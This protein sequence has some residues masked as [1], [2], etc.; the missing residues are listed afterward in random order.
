M[1]LCSRVTRILYI[2]GSVLLP[3]FP[4]DLRLQPDRKAKSTVP[5]PRS[6]CHGFIFI[7]CHELWAGNYDSQPASQPGELARLRCPTASAFQLWHHSGLHMSCQLINELTS[8]LAITHFPPGWVREA[9]REI[10]MGERWEAEKK[11]W[12]DFAAGLFLAQL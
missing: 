8:L 7:S 10:L 4:E 6:I 5:A 1:V 11:N 12:T 3:G 9:R 2:V